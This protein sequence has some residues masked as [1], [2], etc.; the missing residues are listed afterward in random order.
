MHRDYVLFQRADF[1]FM[2]STYG[3]RD[4]RS[5]KE[6]AIETREVVKKAVEVDTKILVPVFA[7]G[8]TQLL[9]YLLAVPGRSG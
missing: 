4:H 3:D 8:R 2:E 1:V 6:T 9:L 7:F 5:L